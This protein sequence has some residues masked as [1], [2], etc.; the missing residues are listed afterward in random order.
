M[1]KNFLEHCDTQRSQLKEPD[2]TIEKIPGPGKLSVGSSVDIAMETID[3]RR[4]FEKVAAL[5]R[6]KG[7]TNVEIEE[8]I[9]KRVEQTCWQ[10]HLLPLFGWKHGTVFQ[11]V[12]KE[13]NIVT[14][15]RAGQPHVL[16]SRILLCKH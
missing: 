11:V 9:R 13:D 15:C 3:V 2:E 12:R 1:K 7:T 8:R 5:R 4:L 10:C 14:V 16:S 6:W